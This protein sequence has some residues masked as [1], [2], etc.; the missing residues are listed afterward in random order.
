MTREEFDEAG[1]LY[2]ETHETSLKIEGRIETENKRLTTLAETKSVVTSLG[3][4]R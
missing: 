2:W 1:H 3:D 4:P